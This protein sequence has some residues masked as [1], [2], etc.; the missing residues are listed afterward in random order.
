[1]WQNTDKDSRGTFNN[2][3]A[4]ACLQEHSSTFC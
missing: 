1:M 2:V 3:T 4:V